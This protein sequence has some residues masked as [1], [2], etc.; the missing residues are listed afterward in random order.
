MVVTSW[1]QVYT[2]AGAWFNF[3]DNVSSTLLWALSDPIGGNFHIVK[4]TD[5]G[6]TW[7]LAPNLPAQTSN[8][9]FWGE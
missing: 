4:S 1:A 6:A 7:A 2:T 9:C 5:A 8:K 3:I